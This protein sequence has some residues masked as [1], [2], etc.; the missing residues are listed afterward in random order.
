LFTR[1]DCARDTFFQEA[2][3]K[4]GHPVYNGPLFIDATWK[5]GYPAPLT[6]TDAI[7]RKVDSRW[8]EYGFK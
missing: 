2:V 1:F 5:N 7:V 8:A 6:M 4:N 3:I